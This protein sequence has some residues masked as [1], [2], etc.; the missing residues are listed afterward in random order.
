M[1]SSA[2]GAAVVVFDAAKWMIIA[3]GRGTAVNAL[4]LLA[5]VEAVNE[6]VGEEV[7][8]SETAVALYFL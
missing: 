1:A 7:V 4:A 8:M 2:V 6:Q 3:T 5:V